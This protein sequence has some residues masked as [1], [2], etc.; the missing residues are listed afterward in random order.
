M[1]HRENKSTT[2]L[3]TRVASDP[4][5]EVSAAAPFVY[6]Q[7]STRRLRARE[8]PRTRWQVRQE[9][10]H[11][12]TANHQSTFAHVR[13]EAPAGSAAAP[14]CTGIHDAAGAVAIPVFSRR[15]RDAKP[16]R[17]EIGQTRSN[18]GSR[19]AVRWPLLQS[20][21]QNFPSESALTN[22]ATN[23]ATSPSARLCARGGERHLL[24]RKHGAF[25]TLPSACQRRRPGEGQRASSSASWAA[26]E[27]PRHRLIKIGRLP[28][29][30]ASEHHYPVH[31]TQQLPW[32]AVPVISHDGNR[33]FRAQH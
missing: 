18:R 4:A 27:S 20:A 21:P 19:G 11:N 6:A 12:F 30:D 9:R 25:R 8:T 29:R 13:G 31:K 26:P 23:R 22:R 2:S 5:K 17:T 16:L 15:D 3:A 1:S 7:R 10:H 28:D 33:R 32:A 14:A 24:E